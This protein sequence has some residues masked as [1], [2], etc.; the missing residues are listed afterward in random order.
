VSDQLR[1]FLE[2]LDDTA[3]FAHRDDPDLTVIGWSPGAVDLLG[4]TARDAVG[5]PISEVVRV[6]DPQLEVRN[7]AARLDR[8]GQWHDRSVLVNRRDELVIVEATV[9]T[10]RMDGIYYLGVWKPLREDPRLRRGR[11]GGGR[12]RQV[13]LRLPDELLG[14]IEQLRGNVPRDRFM[15]A[16]LA[17]AASVYARDPDFDARRYVTEAEDPDWRCGTGER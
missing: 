17:R 11:R 2:C 10:V 3:A 12:M 9:I 1:R 6:G 16:I 15:R 5:R 8:P 4:P 13:N 14:A 7:E